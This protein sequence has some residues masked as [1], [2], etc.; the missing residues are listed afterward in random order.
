[1][2]PHDHSNSDRPVLYFLMRLTDGSLT[3]EQDANPHF[4]GRDDVFESLDTMFED[5]PGP[6]RVMLHGTGG[7]GFVSSKFIWNALT[8]H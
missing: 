5:G 8:D 6:H 3:I 7:I 1:M 4:V 2:L